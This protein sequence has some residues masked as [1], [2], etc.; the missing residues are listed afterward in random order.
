MDMALKPYGGNVDLLGDATGMLVQRCLAGAS[1][2]ARYVAIIRDMVDLVE[3]LDLPTQADAM[4]AQ[5]ADLVAADPR[6]EFTTEQFEETFAAERAF[7]VDRPAEVR[8]SLP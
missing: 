4:H 3:S 5:I 7:L 2:R 1:C 8:A 6:K